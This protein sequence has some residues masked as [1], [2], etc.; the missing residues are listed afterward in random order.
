MHRSDEEGTGNPDGEFVDG[1]G[2]GGEEGNRND[3][4]DDLVYGDGNTLDAD[5]WSK[6]S[7]DS[8]QVSDGVDGGWTLLLG[9]HGQLS[10]KVCP[11]F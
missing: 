11:N 4:D 9:E 3:E 1:L 2:V 10:P 6:A 8:E 7:D 5:M